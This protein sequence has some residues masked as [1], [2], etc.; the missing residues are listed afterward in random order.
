[1]AD[2]VGKIPKWIAAINGPV[3]IDILLYENSRRNNMG[4]AEISNWFL[5]LGDQY[6][7][8][9]FVFGGIYVGAVPFFI[10]SIS[11]LIRRR[12]AKRSIVMPAMSAGFCF[13]A[14][15]LYLAIVG[16][17]IPVW[18]WYFIAALVAY[19]VWSTLR[20]IRR[21]SADINDRI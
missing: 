18:V 6:G 11:W 20:D 2:A 16:H 12:K 3:L 10:I 9:P 1:M 8:N 7:V 15:Y 14:A 4:W 19:G 5:S 21:K 13:I 17:N